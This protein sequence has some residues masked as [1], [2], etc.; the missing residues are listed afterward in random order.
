MAMRSTSDCVRRQKPSCAAG[1]STRRFSE[2]FAQ[3]GTRGVYYIWEQPWPIATTGNAVGLLGGGLGGHS[4]LQLGGI[5]YV[6]KRSATAK[7]AGSE[8]AKTLTLT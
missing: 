6:C 3:D 4:S 8:V 7:R 1:G 2:R 5:V